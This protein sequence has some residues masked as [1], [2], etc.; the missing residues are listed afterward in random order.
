MEKLF[1]SQDSLRSCLNCGRAHED[2]LVEKFTDGDN[3]PLEII[4]CE[5]PRYEEMTIAEFWKNHV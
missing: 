5:H 3:K 1:T 4:V 2:K